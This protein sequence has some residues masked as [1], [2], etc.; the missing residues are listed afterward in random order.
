MTASPHAR[1][2]GT[3]I[4]LRVTEPIAWIFGRVGLRGPTESCAWCRAPLPVGEAWCVDG[5]RVCDACAVRARHRIARAVWAFIAL[6]V[7]ALGLVIYIVARDL[8]QGHPPELWEL[9]VLAAVALF[10]FAMLWFGLWSMRQANRLAYSDERTLA[11]LDTITP[12]SKE[13]GQIVDGHS[14]IT[15]DA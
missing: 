14:D 8:W 6:G 4:L 9:A 12:W 1:G 3:R 15:D 11:L 5:R 7:G 2:L 13:R 10:P